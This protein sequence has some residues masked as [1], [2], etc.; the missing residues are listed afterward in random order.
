[1]PLGELAQAGAQR[2]LAPLAG[3]GKGL[4]GRYSARTLHRLREE[5]KR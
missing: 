4:R 2:P 5:W 1:V 3:S